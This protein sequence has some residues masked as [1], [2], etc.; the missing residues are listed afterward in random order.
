MHPKHMPPALT[1]RT[2]LVQQL[3]MRSMLP[4]AALLEPPVHQL[5]HQL[6]ISKQARPKQATCLPG[7]CPTRPTGASGTASLNAEQQ[8]C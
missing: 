3:H 5:V 6:A 8:P 2:L 4:L 1:L 7:V